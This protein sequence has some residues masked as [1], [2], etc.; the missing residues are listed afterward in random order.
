MDLFIIFLLIY[1]IG[2][3]FGKAFINW[4]NKKFEDKK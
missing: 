4:L 1:L 3:A 2:R